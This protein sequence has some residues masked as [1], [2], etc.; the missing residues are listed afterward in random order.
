MRNINEILK[1]LKLNYPKPI[2][3]LNHQS[4]F[5]LLIST[6][7]S[8]QCTDLRVN[9][10]TPLLFKKYP[11]P[12]KLSV[13]K[14]KDVEKIIHSTGFYRAKSKNIIACSKSLVN[15]FDSV[16]PNSMDKLIELPGV[17]R[18]TANC[19]LSTYYKIFEGVVVDTHVK[20][21]S[22]L[23]GLTKNSSP[24]KIEIDLMK[25]IPKGDWGYYSNALISHG[26]AICT[27]RNP[28]CTICPAKNLCPSA[29]I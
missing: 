9:Q 14:I 24:E 23:L 27:A 5:E 28:K 26:R 6:I 10:V 13:A 25:I 12:K 8:A 22:N 15:N 18:K 29:K 4:A 3:G 20:R 7:L 19:V 17:G 1:I 2:V 16:V 21:I 11:N